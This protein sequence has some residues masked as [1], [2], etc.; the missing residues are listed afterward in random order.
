MGDCRVGRR[1]GI[2]FNPDGIIVD[3]YAWELGINTKNNQAEFYS[4]YMGILLAKKREAKIITILGDSYLFI[5][6][7]RKSSLSQDN[8]LSQTL[9]RAQSILPSFKISQAWH[10]L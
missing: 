10:I 1:G 8:H 7:L 9:L 4:L 5:R 3:K 2:L 6:H